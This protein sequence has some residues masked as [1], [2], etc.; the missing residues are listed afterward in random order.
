MNHKINETK[1]SR[2]H[3]KY[4]DEVAPFLKKELG[5]TN[6]LA[7]PKLIKVTINVGTGKIAKQ[8]DLVEAVG[9]TLEKIS[10]QKPI[11]TLAKKSVASFK[12]RK[13]AAIGWKVTL[14]GE[15]MYEFVDKLVNVTLPRVRDFRGLDPKGFDKQGNYSIG[16]KEQIVFPEVSSDSVQLFHG[17][18]VTIT[19]SAKNPEEGLLLLKKLGFPFKEN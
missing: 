6:I 1:I 9:K 3:K 11:K 19:T 5:L 17:L 10:G 8:T 16:F 13:G 4:N 12:V 15:R 18:E 7:C 2:L 14:R